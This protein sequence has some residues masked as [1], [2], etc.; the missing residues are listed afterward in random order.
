ML[1]TP[2]SLVPRIGIVTTDAYADEDPDQDTPLLLA[3]LHDR[4]V[5]AEA[6]VWHDAA[7]DLA[8]FDLLVLRSP[9]DYPERAAEFSAWLDRAAAATRVVNSPATVRWNLDKRYLRDLEMHGIDVVPTRYCR[10]STES[11]AALAEHAT[12]RV[13]VKPAVSAGARGTGLFDA[14]DPAAHALAERITA[15]GGIA[16]IQPEIPELT[17][18]AEKALYAIDGHFTHAIAKGALLAPGGG[19]IGG[20]YEERP[21]SVAVTAAERA[22]VDAV[23]AAVRR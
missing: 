8:A 5:A 23:L 17:A 3:A 19:F 10:T 1:V 7:V 11:R 15:G 12:S 22:F 4:G 2:A 20:V 13:V 16:M 6:I 21:E 14:H 18:G 9:W